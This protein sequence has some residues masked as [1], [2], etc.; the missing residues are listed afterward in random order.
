L[1]LDF[2]NDEV[3]S[4][5]ERVKIWLDNQLM[6]D[7]WSSLG[8]TAPAATVTFVELRVYT[9]NPKPIPNP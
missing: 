3:T 9:R 7:Q 4:W 6:I 2:A 8:N 1:D 5:N